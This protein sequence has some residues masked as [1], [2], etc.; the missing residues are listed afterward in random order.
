MCEDPYDKLATVRARVGDNL[1]V[2]FL[3]EA[4]C[5]CISF[6]MSFHLIMCQIK[7]SKG[8]FGGL[9]IFMMGEFGQISPIGETSF[10][11]ALVTFCLSR[12]SLLSGRKRTLTVAQ[13]AHLFQFIQ[14]YSLTEQV[15]AGSDEF[16]C[17]LI[18]RFDFSAKES[19]I[20]KAVLDYLFE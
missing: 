17:A 5:Q 20:N 2:V 15:R 6:L 1:C 7:N 16:W 14:R 8:P 11:A 3:D 18:R 10:V 4:S 9:S 13:A 19:S 12:Q